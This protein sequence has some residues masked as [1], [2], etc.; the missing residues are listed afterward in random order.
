MTFTATVA[1]TSGTGTPTGTVNFYSCTSS[2]CTA[3]HHPARLG[4]LN[5]GKATFST[6]SSLAV[7]NTYV[8][9]IYQGVAGSFGTSTSNVVTQVVNVVGTTTSL[10]SSPEPVSLWWLGWLHRHGRSDLG[11]RDADRNG[12]LLLLHHRRACSSTTLLGS[13]TSARARPPSYLDPA[14]RKHLRR[15]HLPGC[16]R[17][18]RVQHLECG[19][20]GGQQH[21]HL[22]L[23]DLVAQPVGLGHLGGLHRHGDQDLWNRNTHWDRSSSTHARPRPAA[24]TTLLG[25]A[26]LSS[27]KATFNTS[28]LPI[29][30][31]YVEAI[32]QGV[33]G[34]FGASTSNVVT[35]VV[36]ANSTTTA[37]TSS[38]NPSVSGHFGDPERHGVEVLGFG[39]AEWLGQLLHR[40]AEWHPHPVG[41]GH[42]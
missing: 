34:S 10:T 9:A 14:G 29:G 37:L 32:Y 20:P 28:T 40:H 26:N 39:H 21:R 27:G 30:T 3:P 5:S 19:H 6:T 11:Q 17:V 33:S 18:L 22:D 42:A 35:Q 41:H 2:T 24:R 31:T 8:E 23:A 38:P 12:Q 25:S 7:G 16:D 36:T 13:G 15:G 4:N 1:K